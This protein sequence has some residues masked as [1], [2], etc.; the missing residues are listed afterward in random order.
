MKGQRKKKTDRIEKQTEQKT[1]KGWKH[2]LANR[3]T[4]E[5]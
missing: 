3:Q 1:G 2:T 5:Q 4:E